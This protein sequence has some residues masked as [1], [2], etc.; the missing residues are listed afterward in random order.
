MLE[1]VDGDMLLYRDDSVYST[2]VYLGGLTELVNVTDKIEWGILPNGGEYG[3]DA[4]V[5]HLDHISKQLSKLS[6]L[7]TVIHEGPRDGE[8]YQYGNYHDGSWY[9]I[10]ELA[11]YA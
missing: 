2:T 3:L 4:E 7:I 9:R 6:T 11:G 10:G 1:K 5:I 8:I